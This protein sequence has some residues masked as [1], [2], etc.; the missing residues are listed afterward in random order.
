MRQLDVYIE[1]SGQE[2]L[3][4]SIRG[5]GPSDAVF[6]YDFAFSDQGKAIS[7]HLPLRKEAFSP[8]ETRCFF[9]GLLPEGFSRKTVASWLRADEED[10]LTILSELG[11]ECLGAIRVEE[12]GRY[13]EEEPQY[14]LL[15]LG[16]VKRLAAEGVSKSTEILVE[17]H[18]SLTGASGKV[19]LFFSDEKWYQPFGTAP[20]THILKQS[21]IRFR[22][23]VENEQLVLRTAGKLGLSTVESFV[24]H[25]GGF[26]E[27]DILLATKRYDRDL[28][29]SQKKIGEMS[30]PLRLHQEDFAQALGIPGNRKYEGLGEGYLEKIFALLRAISENPM[31][32][33]LELL[34]LLIYDKLVG[35]TDNH[36]KN[37]SLLYNGDLSA[38]R[39]AP[40]YD[41]VSTIIYKNTA[42]E[43]SI[44]IGRELRLDRI[45]KQSFMDSDREIGLSR[46]LIQKEYE[47]LQSALAGAM[48]EVAGE[49]VEE[50]FL[51]APE[52]AEKILGLSAVENA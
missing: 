29:H 34:D 35:N 6:S 16:D 2:Y 43:M 8:D 46:N 22:H 21:H 1:I 27:S 30:C 10:Y 17:S 50:G 23:L 40:A 19:G 13:L 33:Q 45:S 20:S 14:V 18:L 47:R 48:R 38:A 28:T 26:E 25:T 7:V 41:L 31:Q 12:N 49:M 36:I 4:G 51:A 11:K 42:A 44:A 3:A 9:E 5:D 15:S 37:L 52:M 24:V 32:D 39:L